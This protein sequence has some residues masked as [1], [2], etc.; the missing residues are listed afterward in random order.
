MTGLTLT[1]NAG[2]FANGNGTLEYSITGTPS[3][4][5]IA[6]FPISIGG[7]TCTL[8]RVV[9]QLVGSISAAINPPLTIAPFT[10]TS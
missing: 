10:S 5:G 4:S 9:N 8:T 2:T 6:S 1:V 3:G 7:R